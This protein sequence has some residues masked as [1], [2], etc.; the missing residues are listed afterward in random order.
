MDHHMSDS[1]AYEILDRSD[2]RIVCRTTF[3][4]RIVYRLARWL[5]LVVV[6]AIVVPNLLYM[7]PVLLL[8]IK[9]G[10]FTI[11]LP[12][13]PVIFTFM[14]VYVIYFSGTWQIVTTIDKER[15]TIMIEKLR[16]FKHKILAIGKT[17]Q[18]KEYPLRSNIRFD[19]GQFMRI[20]HVHGLYLGNMNLNREYIYLETDLASVNALKNEL[21]E[22]LAV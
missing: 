3:D 21:L 5:I 17:R 20:T 11:F 15:G 19:I 4:A 8:Y 13:L 16:V 12:V 6:V 18:R 2:V 14:E 1:M 10:Q 22:F 7:M 9:H